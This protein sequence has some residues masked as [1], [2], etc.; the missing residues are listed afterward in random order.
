MPHGCILLSLVQLQSET[1]AHRSHFLQHQPSRQSLRR[2]SACMPRYAAM[3]STSLL[4]QRHTSSYAWRA[5]QT[6]ALDRPGRVVAWR[7]LHGK[8]F[9]GAFNRHIHRGTPESHLC[10]LPGSVGQ[11]QPCHVQLPSVPGSLAVVS[12]HMDGSDPAAS[13]STAC[14]SAAGRRQAW[15]MAACRRVGQLVAETSPAGHHTAVGRVLPRPVT[16]RAAGTGSVHRGESRL[17]SQ[18]PD[19]ARLAACWLRHSPP[20]WGAQPL[21][22]GTAANHDC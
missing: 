20:N 22:Q 3:T 8:L 12:S 18:V 11:P 14:R 21:A 6:A 1:D 4:W 10:S 15:S 19:E 13:T 5:A 7:L 2:D 9:V 16:A 17:S